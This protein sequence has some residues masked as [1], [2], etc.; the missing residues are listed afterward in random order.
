MAEVLK[1]NEPSKSNFGKQYP[2]DPEFK[3]ECRLERIN[4]DKEREK[5]LLSGNGFIIVEPN[6]IKK[7]IANGINTIFSSRYGQTL[8]DVNAFADR[9]K[10][11]CGR[12][13]SRINHGIKCPVCGER[14]KFL[15]DDFEYFGWIVLRGD[16]YLIHP[17]LYKSLEFLIG[18]TKLYNIIH[19][20]DEKDIN[21]YSTESKK[22]TEQILKEEPF[23]GIGMISLKERIEEVLEFYVNK[24]PNKYEYYNDIMTNLDIMF[25]Q[26]IDRK[27]VV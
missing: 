26:S 11:K 7:D 16:Y 20:V 15:D 2:F 5:D 8:Q 27:S 6:S 22:T 23:Y 19:R 14:V 25:I 1:T 12:L 10:C 24:S 9:Y 4:L 17:N 18:P 3:Y 21:G 13:K